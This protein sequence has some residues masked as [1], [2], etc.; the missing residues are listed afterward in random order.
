MVG[1]VARMTIAT[2]TR[3]FPEKLVTGVVVGAMISFHSAANSDR[4]PYDPQ[5]QKEDFTNCPFLRLLR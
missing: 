1:I 3:L 2:K 4:C 5:H